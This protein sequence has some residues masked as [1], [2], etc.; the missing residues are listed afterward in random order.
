MEGKNRW[1]AASER[2]SARRFFTI[3]DGGVF[4]TSR[5]LKKS[6]SGVPRLAEAA[7]R[8]RSHHSPREVGEAGSEAQRTAVLR[9][10]PSLAAALLDGLF[11]HSER[12]VPSLSCHRAMPISSFSAVD[13]RLPL[14]GTTGLAPAGSADMS[15]LRTGLADRGASICGRI[16]V[17][18]L[19]VPWNSHGAVGGRELIGPG[20]GL[21]M[22]VHFG[23]NWD[24]LTKEDF[25]DC[26]NSA[27]S[28]LTVS[29]YL[30]KKGGGVLMATKKA[31]AKKPAK[32][33]AAKKKK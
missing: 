33:A 24:N 21:V 18:S 13:A 1:G 22:K 20:P 9:L 31:A 23:A 30:K 6:S 16:R 26:S 15:S 4:A 28:L 32:K 5:M 10:A 12:R 14:W 19:S 27:I 11:E 8:G 2:P 17:A 3:V 25:T 7:V 29:P